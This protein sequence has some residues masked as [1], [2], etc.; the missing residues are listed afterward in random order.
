MTSIPQKST[1]VKNRSGGKEAFLK[2][3]LKQRRDLQGKKQLR[4]IKI[5]SH[6]QVQDV[7]STFNPYIVYT[8]LQDVQGTRLKI[9]QPKRP[10]R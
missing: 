3:L 10:K 5:Q 2:K 7:V 1:K 6:P 9:R 4:E 8:I